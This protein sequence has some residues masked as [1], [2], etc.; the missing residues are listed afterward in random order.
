MARKHFTLLLVVLLLSVVAVGQDSGGDNGGDLPD[1]PGSLPCAGSAQGC[2]ASPWAPWPGYSQ[3]TF[4]PFT[5]DGGGFD[6]SAGAAGGDTSGTFNQPA[7]PADWDGWSGGDL[8]LSVLGAPPINGARNFVN[9]AG[10]VEAGAVALAIGGPTAAGV[11]RAIFY[12]PTFFRAGY[13]L[14]MMGCAE[15]CAGL[16]GEGS[17]ALSEGGA[18]LPATTELSVA[19]KLQLYLLNPNHPE[20]GPKAEFFKQALGFTLENANQL[21]KQLTFNEE[22]A[23]QTAVT[24]YGTKFSQVIN[25]VGANGRVIPIQTIWIRNTDKVVRLVTAV[26][27]D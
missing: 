20:G 18:A 12:S 8:P 27:G 17:A 9:V 2:G 7:Q 21:A 14:A 22:L 13:L 19:R 11:G 4:P 10:G 25:V 5:F 23:T 1:D 6:Q 16:G 3:I 26:P 15:S 24:Q